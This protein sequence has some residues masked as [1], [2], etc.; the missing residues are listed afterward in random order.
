M[1]M[2]EIHPDLTEV[3][4]THGACV[5]LFCDSVRLS[6]VFRSEKQAFQH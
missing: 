6:F 5:R 2:M 1:K 3:T 4:I